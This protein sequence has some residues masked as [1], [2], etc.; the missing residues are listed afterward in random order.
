MVTPTVAAEVAE[1][2]APPRVVAVA[3]A[4]VVVSEYGIDSAVGWPKTVVEAWLRAVPEGMRWRLE[5]EDEVWLKTAG[6]RE[7]RWFSRSY[8]TSKGW[9][10][11]G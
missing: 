2:A 1:P 11:M 10:I 4:L 8:M 7:M 3:A 5:E 9:L 6:A